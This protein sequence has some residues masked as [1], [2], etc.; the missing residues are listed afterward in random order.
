[1]SKNQAPKLT[2]P[3]STYAATPLYEAAPAKVD[4]P[5]VYFRNTA[6]QAI[7]YIVDVSPQEVAWL[8]RV[9]QIGPLTY[10]VE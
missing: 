7:E 5:S 9:N 10:F 8:G 1:M 6:L 2:A 4:S 3:R